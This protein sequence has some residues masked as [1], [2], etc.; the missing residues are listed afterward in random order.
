MANLEQLSVIP[1]GC[2]CGGENSLQI[3]A[4]VWAQKGSV[5]LWGVLA[6]ACV[7]LNLGGSQLWRPLSVGRRSNRALIIDLCINFSVLENF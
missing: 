4:V 1:C 2:A 5:R 3:Q 7:C 6:R